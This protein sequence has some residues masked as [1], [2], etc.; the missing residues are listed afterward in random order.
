[1]ARLSYDN[2]SH[3]FNGAMP[4]A[5]DCV[6][7]CRRNGTDRRH[8]HGTLILLLSSF[9]ILILPV[10]IIF[11][12]TDQYGD[13]KAYGSAVFVAAVITSYPS[14][15]KRLDRHGPSFWAFVVI[16]ATEVVLVAIALIDL[17]N[18]LGIFTSIFWGL[19]VVAPPHLWQH[20]TAIGLRLISFSQLVGTDKSGPRREP[21]SFPY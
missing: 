5:V 18:H 10:L 8:W 1:M 11:A 7:G 19:A 21:R 16:T 2:Y 20:T 14:S 6:V 4:M 12:G 9:M 15:L 13:A 17:K 3:Y